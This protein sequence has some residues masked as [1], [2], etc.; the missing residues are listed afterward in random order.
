MEMRQHPRILRHDREIARSGNDFARLSTE[1]LERRQQFL[2]WGLITPDEKM[3]QIK[4][5]KMSDVLPFAETRRD[6]TASNLARDR[7]EQIDESQE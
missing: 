2:D 1:G 7:F 4:K 3:R 6:S 5:R